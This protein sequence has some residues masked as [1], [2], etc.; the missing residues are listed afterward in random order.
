MFDCLIG[1]LPVNAVYGVLCSRCGSNRCPPLLLDHVFE[2]P[3]HSMK[4]FGG[5]HIKRLSADR[6]V[7]GSLG[8]PAQLFQVGHH[9]PPKA[10]S[11]FA[12]ANG[13]H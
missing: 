8:F 9:G 6:P 4:P 13:L 10:Q 11:P 2:M 1:G 7:L 3:H 5:C 12:K